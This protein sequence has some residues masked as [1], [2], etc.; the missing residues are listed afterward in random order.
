MSKF[1]GQTKVLRMQP[2]LLLI[3]V[4]HVD[5]DLLTVPRL[6]P[7]FLS[8]HIAEKELTKSFICFP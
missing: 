4:V 3:I 7:W 2:L 5:D 6:S 1:L 8:H